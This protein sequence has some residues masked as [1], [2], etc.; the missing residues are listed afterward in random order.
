M[1]RA[2]AMD[3][4]T[5]AKRCKMVADGRTAIRAV[6]EHIG[7]GVVLIQQRIDHL[8]IMHRCIR[9]SVLTNQFVLHIDIDVVLVA[10][11]SLARIGHPADIGV[12]L[13][14]FT[15]VFAK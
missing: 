7:I 4:V 14:V 11:R 6:A 1:A 3:A 10:E 9:D 8:R 15:R 12:L 2:F 13:T 5:V